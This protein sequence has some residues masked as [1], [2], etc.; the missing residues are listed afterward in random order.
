MDNDVLFILSL[1]KM[2]PFLGALAVDAIIEYTVWFLHF[3]FE[4][5]KIKREIFAKFY[6][7]VSLVSWGPFFSF[8]IQITFL[9]RA[10]CVLSIYSPFL[11]TGTVFARFF[12][13]NRSR[14]GGG[15]QL[16]CLAH[17]STCVP[18]YLSVYFHHWR[19]S[20]TRGKMKWFPGKG[21]SNNGRVFAQGCF[22]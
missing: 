8:D 10:F 18:L 9:W 17:P 12:L 13:V 22:V 20:R 16:H 4:D 6:P 15:D 21:W 11:V 19:I 7:R 2:S 5:R 1:K 14:K 3:T